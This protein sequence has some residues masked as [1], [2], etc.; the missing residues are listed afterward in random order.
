MPTHVKTC[1]FERLATGSVAKVDR[2]RDC[3]CLSIHIGAT[4]LRMEAG[5][6]KA[7]A[8]TLGESVT[9][10][11]AGPLEA[12]SK[13]CFPS[14]TRGSAWSIERV[15]SRIIT[16]PGRAGCVRGSAPSCDAASHAGSC[17]LPCSEPGAPAPQRA[18]AGRRRSRGSDACRAPPFSARA[19]GSPC[20]LGVTARDTPQEKRAPMSCPSPDYKSWYPTGGS[21]SFAAFEAP[22]NT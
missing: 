6:L 3:G 2:C 13:D 21:S 18:P 1:S 20:R 15:E 17:G 22:R 12:L 10:M 11:Q 16:R 7:L 14:G 5:A 9:A 19:P 8:V 4:T